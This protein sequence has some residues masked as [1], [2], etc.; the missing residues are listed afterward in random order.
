MKFTAIKA[1][2]CKPTPRMLLTRQLEDAERN[3]ID[4]QLADEY[5]QAMVKMLDARIARIKQQLQAMNQEQ[6]E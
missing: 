1:L 2:F 3:K 6:P 5:H 4:H